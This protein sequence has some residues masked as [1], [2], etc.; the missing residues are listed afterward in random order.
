MI[1]LLPS[2]RWLEVHWGKLCRYNP[3]SLYRIGARI[4]AGAEPPNGG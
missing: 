1:S 4:Y 3:H 2:R